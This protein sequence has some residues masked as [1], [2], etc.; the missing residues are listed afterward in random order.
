MERLEKERLAKEEREAKLKA[1]WEALS[2]EE[3]FYR[4]S[5]DIFKEPCIKMRDL[6]Q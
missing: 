4:T 5:E 1:E 2:E 3:R 6:V